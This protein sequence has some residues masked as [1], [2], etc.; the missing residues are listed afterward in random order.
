MQRRVRPEFN[1]GNRRFRKLGLGGGQRSIAGIRS[2]DPGA[3]VR[4]REQQQSV[5]SGVEGRL[6]AFERSP[7]I[8]WR[9]FRLS[10][11]LKRTQ[12]DGLRYGVG[13]PQ[14]QVALLEWRG[15]DVP[16]LERETSAYAAAGVLPFADKRPQLG[17]EFGRNLDRNRREC[18]EYERGNVCETVALACRSF[19]DC[20]NGHCRGAEGEALLGRNAPPKFFRAAGE[21]PLRHPTVVAGLHVEREPQRGLEQ[22]GGGEGL[23]RPRRHALLNRP[24]PGGTGIR[25]PDDPRR[26]HAAWFRPEPGNDD[27]IPQRR[28]SSGAARGRH[29]RERR[30]GS[31]HYFGDVG[32]G[33]GPRHRQLPTRPLREPDRLGDRMDR[34]ERGRRVDPGRQ[35]LDEHREI[36]RRDR[37]FQPV[38]AFRDLKREDG[39]ADEPG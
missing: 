33:F 16:W 26:V 35:P 38:A 20:G 39:L 22:F 2:S 14:P 1:R 21:R 23:R 5:S 7:L 28:Q 3:D 17:Q 29:D 6:A 8:G 27:G 25:I 32:G 13:S 15:R 10:N 18:C 37:V 24:V 34:L 30:D 19:F 11:G 31:R 36:V 4:F 9:G 12:G